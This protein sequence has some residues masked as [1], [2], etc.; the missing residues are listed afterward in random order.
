MGRTVRA[1]STRIE[2]P[3]WPARS[4]AVGLADHDEGEPHGQLIQHDQLGVG[5]EGPGQGQNLLLRT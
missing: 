4:P 1:N 3:A 5:A 2:S